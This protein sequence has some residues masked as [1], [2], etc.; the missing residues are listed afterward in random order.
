MWGVGR[1]A[2]EGRARNERKIRKEE[3][4]ERKRDIREKSKEE[5][6]KREIKGREA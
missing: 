3:R 2:H 6:H 1:R 5:R 4:N